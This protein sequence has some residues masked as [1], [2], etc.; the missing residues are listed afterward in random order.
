MRQG[1]L[2]TVN[3][4]Q[5][6]KRK[7]KAKQP[8]SCPAPTP[9]PSFSPSP[10]CCSRS[11]SC[12]CSCCCSSCPSPLPAPA[13]APVPARPPQAVNCFPVTP[14]PSQFLNLILLVLVFPPPCKSSTRL[15]RLESCLVLHP[16]PLP[17][18]LLSPSSF[19]PLFP[20]T[21]GLTKPIQSTRHTRSPIESLISSTN[22]NQLSALD[23]VG[24]ST[25]RPFPLPYS[26]YRYV[27]F[28][29]LCFSTGMLSIH[30]TADPPSFRVTLLSLEDDAVA[31]WYL[32]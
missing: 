14:P 18:V 8:T 29:P 16:R 26:T 6:P 9:P 32:G 21:L 4:S 19:I 20:Q 17:L 10:C 3:H 5:A 2:S 28:L 24:G 1:P 25:C 22:A 13:P 23:I 12:C 27:L 15:S 30:P 11:C 7:S 31:R